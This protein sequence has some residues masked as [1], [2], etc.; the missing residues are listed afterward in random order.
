[1]NSSTSSSDLCSFSVRAAIYGM[2][3]LS[4]LVIACIFLP[5]ARV[6]TTMLGAQISKL[7]ALDALPGE[8]VVIVGGSGCGQGLVTSNICEVLH[9]PVYNMGLHAGLGLIYQMLAVEPL[10]RNGDVVLIVPE[11]ANFDGYSCF[12]DVELLMMV[13]DII[14]EHKRLISPRQ[15]LHLLPLMPKYGADKLRVM[16]DM[17]AK[18]NTLERYDSYGDGVYP[19]GLAPDERLPFPIASRMLA[20]EYSDVV[21]GYIASFVANLRNREV[22]VYLIPPALQKSSY[23][24]TK[25]FVEKI[26][27]EMRKVGYPFIALPDRYALDDAYFYDTP[28]HLNLN[29][30]EIRT[31][32]LTEDVVGV[33]TRDGVF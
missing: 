2:L 1:M 13:M 12:G 19:A 22:A 24:K 5:S 10:L 21:M 15:W 9:R 18:P 6:R 11:Y 28:Y 8:R 26:D 30:R 32:L 20:T 31:A 4:G 16:F 3:L 23:E 14:P 25:G 27:E 7:K 29:G 17:S 33:L